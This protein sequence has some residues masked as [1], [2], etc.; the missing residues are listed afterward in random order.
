MYTIH[1]ILHPT[2]FSP[3]AGF[4]L[5]M[6]CTLAK[7]HNARLILLQVRSSIAC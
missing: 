5:Q 6:A 7:D 4:A 3:A 1:T 2:D